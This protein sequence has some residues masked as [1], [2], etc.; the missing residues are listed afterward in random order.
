[1]ILA[2]F[3][4]LWPVLNLRRRGCGGA[5]VLDVRPRDE[6]EEVARDHQGPDVAVPRAAGCKNAH[7]CV[8][9]LA[10]TACASS[11]DNIFSTRARITIPSTRAPFSL[12]NHRSTAL[13]VSVRA[14]V[15]R[16]HNN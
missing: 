7:H 8:V 14:G 5:P 15:R 9:R 13:L 3:S 6:E 16:A 12:Q 10:T 11:I 2:F 4:H 1:M